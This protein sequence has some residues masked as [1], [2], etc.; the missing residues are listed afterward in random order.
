MKKFRVSGF[1]FQVVAAMATLVGVFALAGC[2]QE[3]IEKPADAP[4]PPTYKGPDFL[5]STIA[6]LATLDGYRPKLVSGYGLVVNL[7]GTGSADVPPALREWLLT[8]MAKRGFGQ[9]T[10]GFGDLTPAEVLAS[11]RT[12]VVEVRGV[13]P[14]GA[15]PGTRFDL[16][17]RA[18]PQTQTTSL[19]GGLL[20]TTELSI[21]KL[22]LGA[23]G[24]DA[25]AK[26]RG[27]LFLNPFADPTDSAGNESTV[28]R[29]LAG[30]VVTEAMPMQLLT[31]QPSYRLTRQIADRINGR[32]PPDPKDKQPIAVPKSDTIIALNVVK[33]FEGD[34]RRM[35][36]LLSHLYMNPT[37][38]F[39]MDKSQ[40]LIELLRQPANYQYADDIAYAL[41]GMGKTILPILRKS[42]EDEAPTVRMAVLKAAAHLGDQTAAQPLYEL[43]A[44]G[45]GPISQQATNM[46]GHLLLKRPDNLRVANLLR[47]CVDVDDVLVRVAAAEAMAAAGDPSIQQF[48]FGETLLL[49]Q[50]K[51]EKPMLYVTRSGKPRIYVF[52]NE[53][54][55]DLPLLFSTGDNR[56]MLRGEKGDDQI[57][58]FYQPP[59]RQTINQKIPANVGYL[60]GTMAFDPEADSKTL[61]LGIGYGRIVRVLHE[62]TTS[63][64]IAAPFVLQQSDLAQRIAD[65]AETAPGPR[66]ETEGE[67]D[68]TDEL[69]V[70]DAP[71]VP[72]EDS[73]DNGSP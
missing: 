47:K 40:E 67:T 53:L 20:Y 11:D 59:G 72:R 60:I 39:A 50:V 49:T 4:P 70:P 16:M 7:D 56:F 13:I 23:P 57:A 30:G 44:G 1:R 61:G 73:G 43:A 37:T 15:T 51:C 52:N 36:D 28:A 33:R 3:T 66:A 29:V 71:V 46:L 26:G 21:G 22:Q 34:T 58:V 63:G 62:L 55:F 64:A 38:N 41:E 6:S 31:N 2:Q 42:Y 54:G 19:A 9:E 17:V 69:I 48:A 12:A 68:S 8:E 32:F 45:H 25:S 5:R 18:L 14:P 65:S 27:P 10:A 24:F 35:L